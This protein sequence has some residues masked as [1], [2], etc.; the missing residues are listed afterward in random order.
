MPRYDSG[1]AAHSLDV[2]RR[3]AL[4]ASRAN[5]L[6]LSSKPLGVGVLS[7]KARFFYA[8]A[9]QADIIG[10]HRFWKRGEANPSQVSLTFSGQLED[11]FA[12]VGAEA[13]LVSD[14]DDGEK[15]YDGAFRFEHRAKETGKGLAYFRAEWRY[16]RG[17]VASARSFAADVA[18]IDSGVVPLFMLAYFQ[19]AGIRVVPILHSCLWPKGFRPSGRKQRVV[20]FLNGLF[21][22]W[23][24]ESILVVSPEVERQIAEL[25]GRNHRPV[26]QIRAQFEASFFAG[27]PPP[28]TDDSPFEVL[29]VGRATEEKGVLDIPEMAVSVERRAPG[30]VRWTI[31]GSGPALDELSAKINELQLGKV[32]NARGW[33][34]P[35]DLKRLYAGCHVLVIPTRANCAEGLAMT[36]VEA[37]LAGRPIVTSPVVPALELLA[38]A[39][40]AS[41]PNDPES[42]A[43]A[44]LTL[45]QD[46]A[47]YTRL[48]QNSRSL[49][50]QFYDRSLGLTAVLIRALI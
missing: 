28:K 42:Y 23:V 32:V 49:G 7:H 11:Y 8:S 44:V 2:R 33:T 26:H 37:V 39:A 36:A 16:C 45:A 4:D 3:P 22:R 19:L 47:L 6:R 40:M 20:Q 46:R 5:I 27:I 10:S 12:A 24:A 15:L 38:P 41:C 17:L 29:F 13:F 31:C 34:S 25:S 9:G 48:V 43:D 18:I 35:S 30:A 1:N 21:L 50:G 14:R